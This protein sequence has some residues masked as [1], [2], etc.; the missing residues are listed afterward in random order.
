MAGLL[1]AAGLA[2][3]APL[4]VAVTDG[5]GRALA[6][7]VVSVQVRGQQAKAA[8]GTSAEIAQA[9]KRFVPEV[10]VVQAGTA[11]HFPNRDTVRHHVYSFSAARSFELKLYIGT[12]AEPVLF[13]K[14][15]TAVLGCNVHDRMAAWVHVVDTPY[16]A[17]TDDSGTARLEVPAGHH[18][19]AVWHPRQPGSAPPAEQPV[20]VEVAGGQVALRVAV[21]AP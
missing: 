18:V 8:P 9:G 16:F 3:A 1:S 4:T 13:D 21:N 20:T 10:T 12:P 5:D 19:L 17:R 2:A 14:A 6:D 7:A 11:I 15:G